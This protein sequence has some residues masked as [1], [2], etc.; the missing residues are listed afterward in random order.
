MNYKKN[1]SPPMFCGDLE[2]YD[3]TQTESGLS[4]HKRIKPL[5]DG[6]SASSFSTANQVANNVTMKP[7]KFDVSNRT[8]IDRVSN[9]LTSE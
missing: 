8:I 5:N 9:Q 1:F 4:L 7:C 2:H 3:T 6:L